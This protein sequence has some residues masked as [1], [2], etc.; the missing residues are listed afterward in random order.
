[1]LER[2]N[3]QAVRAIM[4]AEEEARRFGQNLIGTEQML[5]GLFAEE[6]GIAARALKSFGLKRKLVRASVLGVSGIGLG[7]VPRNIPYTPRAQEA[8]RLAAGE[9]LNL[10]CG[11]IGPEHILLGLLREG[12]GF[13]VRL[14]RSFGVEPH[15]LRERVI[16]I[17]KSSDFKRASDS[18]FSDE[19]SLCEEVSPPSSVQEAL[20]LLYDLYS[21]IKAD[22][23]PSE[24]L[25]WL[26]D[27]DSLFGVYF[28]AQDDNLL[29]C[30]QGI[31][32]LSGETNTYIDYKSIDS[33]E[34]PEED[35]DPYLK[36]VLRPR[37][38]LVML[39][40]LHST[41]DCA[42]VFNLYEFISFFAKPRFTKMDIQ[43]IQSREDLILFLR[44]PNVKTEGYAE[45]ASWLERG[46][47]K[48][49]WLESLNIAPEL[50]QDPSVWRLIALILLRL[51][52][53]VTTE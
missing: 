39:P 38:S 15:A 36:I 14:L 24:M 29:I 2:L 41:E 8:L 17:I 42:D 43:D 9:A 50:L 23:V 11:K 35:D 10:H 16:Q 31:Y 12:D 52:E 40:V 1:M 4:L 44:Q 13:A 6:T 21:F 25:G 27:K 51:P 20:L 48:P 28:N 22:S 5:F 3:E 7:F 46:D 18:D 30:T 47:P 37:D 49:S 32:W 19:F 33:L 26:D 34:L 53:C 45:L